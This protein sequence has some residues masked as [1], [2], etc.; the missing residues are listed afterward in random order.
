MDKDLREKC[1]KEMA[2]L[3]LPG[4]AI[5]GTSIGEPKD[6]CFRMIDYAVKYLQLDGYKI[7]MRNYRC[8]TGE[9]DIIAVKDDVLSFVEV[10]TRYSL[11][12]GRPAETVTFTKQQKIRRIAQYYMMCE[13]LLDNMPIISFDV[14]EIVKDQ[15]KVLLFNHYPKLKKSSSFR[16]VITRSR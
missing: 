3:D 11:V 1:A 15:E 16:L 4:Y 10:K 8:K 13:G 6:V 5:G 14:I 9:I 7:N 2:K 12:A